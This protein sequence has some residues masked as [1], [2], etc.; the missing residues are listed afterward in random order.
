MRVQAKLVKL[1]TV[2]VLLHLLLEKAGVLFVVAELR[3]K[4]RRPV[5]YDCLLALET[6]QSRVTAS[7]VE[8]SYRLTQADNGL[9]LAE[10]GSTLACVDREGRLQ[11]IP[12]FMSPA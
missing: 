5:F 7:R 4:Y 12:E 8:H 9:L 2:S 10:A 3:I 1:K 11:R 6:T